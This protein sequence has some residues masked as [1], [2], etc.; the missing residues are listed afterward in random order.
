L[1]CDYGCF[2]EIANPGY[3]YQLRFIPFQAMLFHRLRIVIRLLNAAG[4]LM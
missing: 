2:L 3:W 1:F 4:G